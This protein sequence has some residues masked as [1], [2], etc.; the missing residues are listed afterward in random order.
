MRSSCRRPR[1][2][3]AC[4]R[5]S[6]PGLF[7]AGSSRAGGHAHRRR[8]RY[9]TIWSATFGGDRILSAGVSRSTMSPAVVIGIVPVI[10]IPGT[11]D[12][13]VDVV[14]RR[15]PIR[16]RVTILARIRPGIPIGD[17]EARMPR[18]R[19]VL[20]SPAQLSE[21]LWCAPLPANRVPRSVR[22]RSAP[23]G[24]CL[25]ASRSCSLPAHQRQQP[26][27]RASGRTPAP[28]SA[29]VPRCRRSA[30][31][32]D[33]PGDGRARADRSVGHGRRCRS[34]VAAGLEAARRVP[35]SDA[36][37]D[38]HRSARARC[39]IRGRRG[40]GDRLRLLPAWLAARRERSDRFAAAARANPPV[41]RPAAGL[42]TRSSSPARRR[43]LAR[44]WSGFRLPAAIVH[45]SRVRGSRARHGR[46][47][48]SSAGPGARRRSG[49]RARQGRPR[50]HDP[51]RGHG[52]R[53][54]TPLDRGGAGVVADGAFGGFLTGAAAGPRRRTPEAS[55]SMKTTRGSRRTATG[56]ARRSSTS[57]GSASSVGAGSFQETATLT[58][59]SA[60]GS[61]TCSGPGRIHRPDLRDRS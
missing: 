54:G 5:P 31:A 17:V 59:S 4:L 19:G 55:A 3:R 9:R 36:Q 52:A 50:G 27:A 11:F 1:C 22:P 16:H 33:P 41:R 18:S 28:T 56:S 15:Q 10:P 24:S 58:S 51:P 44:S 23:C 39:G 12:A 43:S 2:H 35:R 47:S 13:G 40:R 57:T 32:P 60:N 8:D 26:P 30:R 29:C 38:R 14:Q 48:A 25:Q 49:S 37:S 21:P 61:R 45:Q 42:P 34:R 7:A 6:V 20:P 46:G 53:P